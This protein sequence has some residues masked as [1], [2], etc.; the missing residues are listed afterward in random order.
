MLFNPRYY[1][2]TTL[3]ITTFSKM[4]SF[5]TLSITIS[6]AIM[7]SVAAFIDMLRIV[8]P[9]L[10]SSILVVQ[11]APHQLIEKQLVDRHFYY[12]DFGV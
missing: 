12:T 9:L 11:T 3:S 1:G 10:L 5:S 2:A 6:S 7:L 4:G 8:A